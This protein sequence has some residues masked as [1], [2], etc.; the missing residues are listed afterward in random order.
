[1]S[2]DFSNLC[3]I[4]GSDLCIVV[5]ENGVVEW[6][7]SRTFSDNLYSSCLYWAQHI[8]SPLNN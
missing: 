3:E 1:M 4:F 6:A 2:L 5:S 7:T 8:S